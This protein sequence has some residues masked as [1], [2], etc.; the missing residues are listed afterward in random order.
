MRCRWADYCRS[1]LGPD[2]LHLNIEH[3]IPFGTDTGSVS[4]R[5]G[6]HKELA[7][8]A[9]S[10]H[11]VAIGYSVGS[12][13]LTT[14]TTTANSFDGQRASSTTTCSGCLPVGWTA[15]VGTAHLESTQTNSWL[16]KTHQILFAQQFWPE[17]QKLTQFVY[18]G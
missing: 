18:L 10:T 4:M 16:G 12:H 7:N 14:L 2:S 5:T 17:W 15:G 6:W 13:N 8:V 1:F 11:F 9:S 3:F